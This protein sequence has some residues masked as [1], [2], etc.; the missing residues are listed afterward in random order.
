MNSQK[1]PKRKPRATIKDV[2]RLAGVSIASVSRVINHTA[3]V[4]PE[5]EARVKRAISALDYRPHLAARS[6][7]RRRTNTI[8]L[9]LPEFGDEYVS[10]LLRGIELEARKNDMGLLVFATQYPKTMENPKPL[11]DEN[12]DGVVVFVDSLPLADLA[13]FEQIGFPVVLIHRTAAYGLDIPCVTIENRDSARR[14]VDH[15]IDV[16]GYRRIAFLSGMAGHEDSSLREVGYR[17]SLAA[18]GIAYD[19]ALIA[20]GGFNREQAQRAVA[21]WLRT[22]TEID[23]IFCGD[24][25]MA[26]GAL[27]AINRAGKRVPQ[28]IALVGFD[29]IA[30]ARYL[31]PP[32]TTVRAPIEQVGALAVLQ[33]MK[34]IRGEAVEPL[35]LLPTELIIRQSCGCA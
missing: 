25:E 18:H 4:S 30:P 3:D 17:E 5:T 32:L 8:G 34:I 26:M 24:D 29:D 14:A 10:L 7:V 16:H 28:D 23:A 21:K 1:K 31:S 22:Q 6:L 33:L 12:T 9:I 13:R 27:S 11:G 20:E 15:L 19:P 35:V 2:A